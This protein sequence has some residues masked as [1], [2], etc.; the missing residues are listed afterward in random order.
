MQGLGRFPL[1][2]GA[3]EDGRESKLKIGFLIGSGDSM[4]PPS[5]T[6]LELIVYY[7]IKRQEM[8]KT[9]VISILFN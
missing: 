5:G 4:L 1:S 3:I 6:M 8:R 7:L 9:N 2:F